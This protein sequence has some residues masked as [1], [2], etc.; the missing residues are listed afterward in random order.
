MATIEILPVSSEFVVQPTGC[1]VMLHVGLDPSQIQEVNSSPLIVRDGD[2]FELSNDIWIERLDE[3]T[4]K[5]VQTACEPPHYKIDSVGHDH[6]LYAFIMRVPERQQ[7]RFDGLDVLHAVS[8]RITSA[9]LRRSA[10]STRGLMV[11]PCSAILQA[12]VRVSIAT[13]CPSR[14]I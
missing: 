11:M 12:P 8:A 1:Y 10:S 6:H 14:S 13:L 4:A 9:V 5:H 7:T 2:R 3:E